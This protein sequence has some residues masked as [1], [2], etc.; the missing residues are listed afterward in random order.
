MLLLLFFILVG[1]EVVKVK[2]H[3]SCL[4]I[5]SL[6]LFTIME[7]VSYSNTFPIASEN[8]EI[9]TKSNPKATEFPKKCSTKVTIFQFFFV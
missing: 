9:L 4:E 2:H 6:M 1:F 5:M 7:R 3:F 8:L